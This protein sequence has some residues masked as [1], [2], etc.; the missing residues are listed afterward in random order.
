[1]N[2]FNQTQPK[3][4]EE[5]NG[6]KQIYDKNFRTVELFDGGPCEALAKMF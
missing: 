1:M 2:T 5:M 4:N 6:D 3:R